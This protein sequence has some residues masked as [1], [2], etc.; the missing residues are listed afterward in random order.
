MDKYFNFNGVEGHYTDEGE[1]DAILLVHGFASDGSTWQHFK[2]ALKGYRLL[3]PDLPGFGH[4]GLPTNGAGI[5]DMAN[6]VEGLLQHAGVGKVHYVGHS[7]G[8]YVGLD[9]AE[10]NADKLLSFTL[11][12]SQPFADTDEK[13]QHRMKS[14]D[15]IE[16]N[17]TYHYVSELF[18]GLFA[19]GFAEKNRPLVD[20]IIETARRFPAKSITNAL[21]AMANRPDRAG[22]LKSLKV[23]ILFIIGKEDIT[24]PPENS[25]RQT[26]LPNV[27]DVN[28]LQGVAHMGMYEKERKCTEILLKFIGSGF[29]HK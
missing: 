21:Q 13:R 4:S 1:G 8:G 22:I 5:T 3:I 10:N 15:F 14:I 19:L 28:I 26:H 7:M 2:S 23:P 27:A 16:K 6:F 18:N 17:G 25:L 29:G 11:F 24:I 9:F 20:N 12:H